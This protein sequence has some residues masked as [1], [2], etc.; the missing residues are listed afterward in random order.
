MATELT[1]S[2]IPLPLRR[3]GPHK[4][5]ERRVLSGQS[6]RRPERQGPASCGY[7]MT[8]GCERDGGPI[9]PGSHRRRPSRHE[10]A[11]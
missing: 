8:Y 7:R 6:N 11:E 3:S 9:G 4:L 2:P 10:D 1:A 5:D